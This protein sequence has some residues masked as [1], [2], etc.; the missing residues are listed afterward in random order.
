MK[1]GGRSKLAIEFTEHHAK[2]IESTHHAVTEIKTVLKG[3]NG[4]Q[5]LCKQVENN[6]KSINKIWVIFAFIFGVGGLGIGITELIKLI[7]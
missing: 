6:S 3:Y 1:S 5:G 4:K 2:L 7:K